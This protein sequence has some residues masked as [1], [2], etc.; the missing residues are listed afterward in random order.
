MK[1]SFLSILDLNRLVRDENME[2]AFFIVIQT[3]TQIKKGAKR[4]GE[5][6][7]QSK[8]YRGEKKSKEDDLKE[9]QERNE[10]RKGDYCHYLLNHT[11]VRHCSSYCPNTEWRQRENVQIKEV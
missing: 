9:K 7:Y 4:D 6:E 3:Y 8:A 5:K 1:G 2:R 10:K 11:W